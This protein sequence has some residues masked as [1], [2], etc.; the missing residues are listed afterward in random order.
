MDRFDYLHNVVKME[1]ESILQFPSVLTCRDFR[2][3]Q[4]HEFLVHL[5]RAQYDAKLP[6]YIS[7]LQL[8]RESDA[9]FAVSVAKSSVQEFNDFCKTM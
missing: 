9:H 5:K 6:N 1:H 2:I 4:R 3:K 8:I 7:P